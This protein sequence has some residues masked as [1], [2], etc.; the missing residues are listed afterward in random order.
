MNLFYNSFGQRK[1]KIKI[2]PYFLYQSKVI[3]RAVALPI[4]S[5]SLPLA[6]T[7]RRGLPYSIYLFKAKH[8][9]L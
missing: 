5:P 6:H 9:V 2:K 3:E 4:T 1:E 8:A 7:Q